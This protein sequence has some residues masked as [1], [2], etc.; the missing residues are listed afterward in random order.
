MRMFKFF[1]A[2]LLLLSISITPLSAQQQVDIIPLDY[3]I[4][5]TV[6]TISTAATPIPATALSGRKS[7]I[8]KNL[9]STLTVYIGSSTVTA[10]E[11][12]TGGFPL[13]YYETIQIDLGENT[14]IYGI[15]S[16]T[17]KVIIIEV[18]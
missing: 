3:G 2:G 14:V 12:S 18:R 10:D 8:I 17:A 5:Q 9:S 16:S 11:E 4:L 1:L 7:L 13:G 15:S 6:V